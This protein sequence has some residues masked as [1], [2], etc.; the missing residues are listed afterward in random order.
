MDNNHVARR[1]RMLQ[2]SGT[3]EVFHALKTMEERGV[4]DIVSLGQGQPCFDTPQNIKE[5]ACN[6]LE[7]GKTKYEPTWGDPDLRAA[8]SDKLRK[9]NNIGV[10][11]SEVM[12]TPGAKFALYLSLLAVLDPGDA[13]IILDPAWVSY[14]APIQ[15]AGAKPIRISCTENEG[16]QPD[17]LKIQES[18][19]DNVKVIIL[20]SPCNPTGAVYDPEVIREIARIAVDN[21]VLLL[22]DEIYEKIIFEG[23]HYS[24]GAEFN[25][26]ITVNGFSKSYAMTGW[27]LG[28]VTGPKDILAAMAK[29]YQHSAS[30]VNSFAQAGALE[31]LNSEESEHET[32]R[33]VEGYRERRAVM[34]EL[35]QESEFLTCLPPK[36]TFYAFP[37]YHTGKPSIE[38][39][40]K[41]LEEVHVATIPGSAFGQCGEGHLRLSFSASKE[42]IAEGLQ[43]IE[44]YLKDRA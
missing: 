37:A 40:K 17:V 35:I 19:Q 10:L 6:A 1:I 32:T 36:G 39:S 33:M 20:N 13:V 16:L 2:P 28:Y 27:R 22:S 3:R 7:A 38:F 14:E 43:R 4:E 23:S 29:I 15:M 24:P 5:A 25:N 8:I 31:A 12:V 42:D 26:V 18:V 34:M 30:C 9:D 21:G 11:P 44:R 41:L